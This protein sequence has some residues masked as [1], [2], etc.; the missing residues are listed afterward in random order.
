MFQLFDFIL[1]FLRKKKNML[2]E[3]KK[4]NVADDS[5]KGSI[6]LQCESRPRLQPPADR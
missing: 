4:T 5:L 3:S 6:V 2:R 1:F